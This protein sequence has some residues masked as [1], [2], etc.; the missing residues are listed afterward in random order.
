MRLHKV[1]HPVCPSVDCLV[2]AYDILETES[3]G[4]RRLGLE[5]RIK[6]V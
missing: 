1:L 4:R 3:P 2:P 6:P 5:N